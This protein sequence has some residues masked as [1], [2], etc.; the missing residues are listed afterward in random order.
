VISFIEELGTENVAIVLNTKDPRTLYI[1]QKQYGIP[2]DVLGVQLGHLS[3]VLEKE[4]AV[5]VYYFCILSKKL[6]LEDCFI[7]IQD[8]P[9]R[10]DA[11]FDSIKRKYKILN[12]RP[13]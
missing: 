9:E 2:C 4:E 11:Y 13:N 1:F 7:N 3:T 12:D 10:T 8:S 5:V 6:V